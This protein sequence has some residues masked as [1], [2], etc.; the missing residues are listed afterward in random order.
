MDH[1][2]EGYK[3]ISKIIIDEVVGILYNIINY[4]NIIKIYKTTK[5]Y[6]RRV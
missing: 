2:I 1:D 6:E 5:Y 3:S 4:N